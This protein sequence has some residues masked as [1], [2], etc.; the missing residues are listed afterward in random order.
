MSPFKFDLSSAFVFCVFDGY[1]G[2][3]WLGEPSGVRP[4]INLCADAQI[5]GT[6]TV[7]DPF[8]VVGAS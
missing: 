6:G 8:K 7:D 1:L 5:T 4:V 2:S 3:G